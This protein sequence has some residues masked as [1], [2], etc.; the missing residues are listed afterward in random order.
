MLPDETIRGCQIMILGQRIQCECLDE[1][2]I[3]GRSIIAD[4]PTVIL[5]F[6]DGHFHPF[7]ILIPQ[8]AFPTRVEG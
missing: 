7:R 6:D 2:M 8:R 4:R 5:R 3:A 1:H